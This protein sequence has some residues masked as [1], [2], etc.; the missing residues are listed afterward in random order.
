MHSRS[1]SLHVRMSRR[2]Y[3]CSEPRSEQW[4]L[5]EYLAAERKLTKYRLSNLPVSIRTAQTGRH[6]QTTLAHR[7]RLWKS[8]AR[9]WTRAFQ[10]PQLARISSPCNP[11]DRCLRFSRLRLLEHC[12]DPLCRNTLPL[13]GTSPFLSCSVQPESTFNAC[14]NSRATFLAGAD[15]RCSGGIKT[16]VLVL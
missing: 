15:R 14:R 12:H 6:R 3:W 11:V 10:G 9:T 2:D 4:L 16:R 7:T 5:L 1:A 8:E 13:H